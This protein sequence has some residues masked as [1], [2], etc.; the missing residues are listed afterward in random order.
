MHLF[1]LP[2]PG[3]KTIALP[4]ATDGFSLLPPT[5]FPVS[6]WETS[7]D[8]HFS[9]WVPPHWELPLSVHLQHW[10]FSNPYGDP[11]I[12]LAVD[13]ENKQLAGQYVIAPR[14]Y[15]FFGGYLNCV[16]SLDTLT[17]KSYRGQGI[18]TGLAKDAF[19]CAEEQGFSFCYGAPNPNSHPGFIRKLE[20]V[21]L[22]QMPLYVKP[23]RMSKIVSEHSNKLLGAISFPLNLFSITKKIVDKNIVEI[24]NQN[25]GL[26]D[27]FWNS[28][29]DKY[30]ILGIR[31][32]EYIS[33]RYLNVPT[34]E[35]NPYAYLV[36]GK[37]VAF[38]VSRIREVAKI[39]T[40]MIAD[41][42][43]VQGYEKQAIK[44]AKHTMRLLKDR[45]ANLSGCIMLSHCGETKALKRAGFFKCPD[46]VLPQPTPLI[47]RVF[48]EQLEGKG[49][50]D[51]KNWFFTTG[52]YDVV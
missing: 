24:T 19:Q 10:Y 48:D 51:A 8:L 2:F 3:Q 46:K 33:F 43:F 42:I 31:D 7:G 6:G 16:L 32:A 9:R 14:K 49:I 11:I 52:D 36:D 47:L 38:I 23:L 34:R 21:D 5:C 41:F 13:E 20:F 50:L 27:C 29:K 26:M 30:K 35:Y 28:I 4:F 39:T 40:G 25:V 18:F 22:F 45:G 15:C 44:L 17:R 1:T 37:P 12:K